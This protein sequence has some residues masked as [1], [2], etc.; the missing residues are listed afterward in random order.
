VTR[1]LAGLALALVCALGFAGVAAAADPVTLEGKI[2]C[3]KCALKKA[4]AT[5][6]Q[7]VFVAA[8]ED[9]KDLEY[10]VEKNPTAEKYGE[11]C[12]N[13]KK[14]KIT[15]TISEKDGRRWIAPSTIEDIK[16]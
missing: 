6:C 2:V 10:Y 5:K 15:G 12:T 16:G 4:D 13:A 8:D 3:A 9:G 14:V 7:N 11:V 1:F